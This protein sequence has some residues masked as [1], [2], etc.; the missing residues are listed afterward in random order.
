MRFSHDGGRKDMK[1]SMQRN[2]FGSCNDDAILVLFHFLINYRMFGRVP[3]GIL[4]AQFLL[5]PLLCFLLE[6]E[7]R[8]FKDRFVLLKFTFAFV[9]YCTFDN[10]SII[11]IVWIIVSHRCYLF[12]VQNTIFQ[13]N[14]AI[15]VHSHSKLI[16][17]SCNTCK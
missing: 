7:K 3:I 10:S 17:E 4:V 11:N 16:V 12:D 13:L 6:M 14:E 15:N 1:D 2:F 5:P 9:L 8:I